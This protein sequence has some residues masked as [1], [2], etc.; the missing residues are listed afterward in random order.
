VEQGQDEQDFTATDVIHTGV[1]HEYEE[2][3]QH[4]DPSAP[5][6][7]RA[8]KEFRNI[9]LAP[10]LLT[11]NYFAACRTSIFSKSA[12]KADNAAPAEQPRLRCI[13]GFADD[14]RAADTSLARFLNV[15]GKGNGSVSALTAAGRAAAIELHSPNPADPAAPPR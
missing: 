5:D 13:D 1:V 12:V 3:T 10:H 14:A 7:A 6:T 11:E 15:Q 9:Y 8:L 4:C 2:L